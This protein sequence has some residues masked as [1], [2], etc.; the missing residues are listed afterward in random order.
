MK[1]YVFA[2]NMKRPLQNDDTYEYLYEI[3]IVAETQEEA[4]KQ[5]NHIVGA[6]IAKQCYFNDIYDYGTI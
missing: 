6:K 5:L 3:K 4:I 2:W 1:K